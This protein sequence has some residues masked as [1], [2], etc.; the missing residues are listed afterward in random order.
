MP[1]PSPADQYWELTTS[2]IT[3][4]GETLHRIRATR[5]IPEQGACR[6]PRTR[7]RDSFPHG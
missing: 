1:T 6:Y 7:F 3:H 4:G 5:A 2:T